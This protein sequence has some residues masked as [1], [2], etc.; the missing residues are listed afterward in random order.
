MTFI[1]LGLLIIAIQLGYEPGVWNTMFLLA[2][3]VVYDAIII[4]R[5]LR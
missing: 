3:L 2:W 4:I 5:L 1:Y